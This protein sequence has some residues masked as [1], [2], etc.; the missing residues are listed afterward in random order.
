[1]TGASAQLRAVGTAF[2]LKRPIIVGPGAMMGVALLLAADVPRSQLAAIGPTIGTMF[3]FFCAEAWSGRRRPV[4]ERWLAWSLRITVTGLAVVCT[5]SGGLRSPFLPLTLAPVVV[6]FAAFGR[7]T[8]SVTLLAYF[9]ALL[10]G[11]ALVPTGWPWPPISAPYD[12]VMT[13]MTSTLTLALAY[14]GVAQLGDALATSREAVLRGRQNALIAA[15]DRLRSLETIGSKVAHEL[16]NPLAAI[17]G[18]AQLSAQEPEAARVK[19]R[20]DVLLA[21]TRRMEDVLEDYLSF[22]RP[23]EDLTLAPV[24]LDGLIGEAV[25]LV[26]TRARLAG[27]AIA[28]EGDAGSVLADRRRL[29]DA[30]LNLLTNAVEASGRGDMV[31]VTVERGTE[32]VEV[33]VKDEGEGLSEAALDR[34]GT[35]YFTT[36]EQGTGLGVV[37]AMAAIRQ[38]GG[39]L[40]FDSGPGRGTLAAF[41]LPIEQPQ[42]PKPEQVDVACSRRG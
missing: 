21:A 35:P 39:Q 28:Q 32:T 22:A 34:L 36:K 10:A 9:V 40:R 26:E 3:L 38:H 42:N 27:V 12:T 19:K 4:S 5:M 29:F 41:E 1:M 33:F 30:L 31:R 8:M 14:V 37:V 6:A 18:L 15:T 20:F 25:E 17:K 2:L 11:L 13:G 23:L 24:D 7:R 16:K